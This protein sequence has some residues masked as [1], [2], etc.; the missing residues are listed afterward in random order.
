MVFS[1]NSLKIDRGAWAAALRSRAALFAAC[2]AVCFLF[3]VIRTPFSFFEPSFVAEDGTGYFSD[4][5]NKGLLAALGHTHNGYFVFGNVLLSEAAILADRVFLGGDVRQVPW[6][7]ALVSGC[8]F[9]LLA[10]LPILLLRRR[11][12]T[13]WLVCLAAIVVGTPLSGGDGGIVGRISNTGYS[14]VY[15]AVIILAYRVCEKPSG[16]RAVMCDVVLFVCANTNPTVIPLLILASIPYASRIIHGPRGPRGWGELLRDRSFLSLIALGVCVM[17]C[18]IHLY[19]PKAATPPNYLGGPFI[20]ANGVEMI[21]AREL[22]YP[23]LVGFYNHLRDSYVVLLAV[24]VLASLVWVLRRQTWKENQVY[25]ITIVG[26]SVFAAASAIFRPGLSAIMYRYGAQYLPQY[27]YGM[28]MVSSL[29]IVLLCHDLTRKFSTTV[30]RAAPMLLFALYAPGIALGGGFGTPDEMTTG[31]APFSQD[32]S[33]SVATGRYA[34]RDGTGSADGT[35]VISNSRPYLKGWCRVFVPKSWALASVKHD[36]SGDFAKFIDMKFISA[37]IAQIR[38]SRGLPAPAGYRVKGIAQLG[39]IRTG[40]GPPLQRARCTW[41]HED[42]GKVDPWRR[43]PGPL[44]E[45]HFECR[46]GDIALV[47]DWTGSGEPSVGIFRHGL[48]LL[49]VGGGR[50]PG[51]ADITFMFGGRPGDIP[52]TGDWNGDGRKKAGIYRSGA[53]LLDFDGDGKDETGD[54]NSGDRTYTFGG[55]PGDVPVVGDWDG[56][57]RDKIGIFGSGYLWVLDYNGNGT[58]DESG[59]GGDISF[60]LGGIPGDIPVTGE[61]NRDGRTKAGVFRDGQ[62]LLDVNGDNRLDEPGPGKDT[63]VIWKAHPGDKPVV[64]T[65]R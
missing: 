64:S 27:F 49:G 12:S 31:P 29:L 46:P 61:W 38:A 44:A 52:V 16:A 51:T 28:N 17:A 58:F 21:L 65:H 18:A 33:F 34:N 6:A 23:L 55:G 1:L 60:P 24:V 15:L 53:W 5:A 47:G 35:E 63:I 62:W 20:W 8:Y 3:L 19:T 26:F 7:M 56:S 11:L 37:P 2:F 57:G 10:T 13:A 9:A 30:K 43:V 59:V 14:F 45:V 48:W 41:V 4:I 39:Y 32:V 54:S 50:R 40:A 36:R 22:L 25:V 42:S